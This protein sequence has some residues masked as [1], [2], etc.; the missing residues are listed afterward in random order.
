MEIN[1]IS[2]KL[3]KNRMVADEKG[4][5]SDPVGLSAVLFDSMQNKV[6]AERVDPPRVLFR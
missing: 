4:N 6:R 2:D 1:E 5:Q 3:T